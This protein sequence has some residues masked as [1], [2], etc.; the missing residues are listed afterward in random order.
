M[1]GGSQKSGVR[2]SV[3]VQSTHSTH[4]WLASSW[5][6]DYAEALSWGGGEFNFNNRAGQWLDGQRPSGWQGGTV[7]SARARMPGTCFRLKA[8]WYKG[9]AG[10]LWWG[11]AAFG[12]SG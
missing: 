3:L 9:A 8:M 4:D 6:L 10:C 12:G 1:G 7:D 11:L 5:Y 2:A